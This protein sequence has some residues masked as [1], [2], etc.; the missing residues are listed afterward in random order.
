[1]KSSK[2]VKTTNQPKNDN[3]PETVRIGPDERSYVFAVAMKYMKDEEAANDVAQD[4]LLLAHRHRDSFRGDSRY[5]TWLYRVAATTALMHLRKKKRRAREV[6]VPQR[7]SDDEQGFE[8]DHRDLASSPEDRTGASEALDKVR[9]RLD[10]LGDKY[11][12]IF[13]LRF[14]EGYTESEIANK[15]DLK[16]TTVKTRAYRARVAVKEHLKAQ[17]A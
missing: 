10:Q 2:R 5:T 17:M 6:L 12:D 16:L 4:A 15:L 11:K 1:S 7:V 13:W 9:D 14:F 3:Q 8:W